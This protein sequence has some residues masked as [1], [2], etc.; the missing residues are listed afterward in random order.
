MTLLEVTYDLES[1]LKPEQLRT[2]GAL[3]NFYGLR[4]YHVNEQLQQI[5]IEFDA[6]RLPETRLVQLLRNANIP[7]VT[8]A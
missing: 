3:A 1:P 4:R 2:I 8:K 7:V 6:S 5:R